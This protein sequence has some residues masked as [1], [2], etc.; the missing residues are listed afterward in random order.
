MHLS[1]YRRFLPLVL[2]ILV[3]VLAI[4]FAIQPRVA[5]MQ[6][7][8]LAAAWE[9][10][11]SAGSYHFDSDVIQVTI[12]SPKVGNVG[13]ASHTEQIHLEGSANL[14]RSTLEMR[15]WS[16]GGSVAQG[17]TGVAVKV[18]QGKTYVRRGTGDWQAAGS[19][20]D[21]MAPQGDF[22]AYL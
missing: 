12:P 13:R 9:R 18:E 16:D 20:T 5:A 2:A 21:G 1:S 19:L 8:P 15:L 17:E 11:R 4:C 3:G 7:D 14:R 6:P 22:M 10:A